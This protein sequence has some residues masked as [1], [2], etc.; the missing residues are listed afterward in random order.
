[1]F[2]L[3]INDG[4]VIEAPKTCIRNGYQIYGY[5]ADGNKKMLLE[6]GYKAFEF[7]ASMA[8]IKDDTII[9]KEVKPV[10]KNIFS[11]LAIRRACRELKLEDK[12]NALLNGNV[13]FAADWADA[14]EINLADAVLIE[15][16]KQGTFTDDDIKKIKEVLQ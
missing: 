6:D 1:M 13:Y 2:Y 9:K 3:K 4:K 10:E 15:A 16:L 11:K 14:N 5:N 12:L 7:P 8:I